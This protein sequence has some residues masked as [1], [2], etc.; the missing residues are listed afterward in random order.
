MKK[1]F[2]GLFTALIS[3][4]C[5][6]QASD[7]APLT[8]EEAMRLTL[9]QNET[10]RA[11][12]HEQKAAQHERKAAFGL[13]LPQ[14]SVQGAYSYMGDDIGVD[15]NELKPAVRKGLEYL[16][17][18]GA[19]PPEFQSV[20]GMVMKMN[21]GLT[22]QEREF[23]FAGASVTF[24]LF[25]GGKIN[26][27]N[28]AA[29]IEERSSAVQGEV[30][31]NQLLLEL[32]ERYYGLGVA[33]QA[34]EVRKQVVEVMAVHLDDAIKL[35]QNGIIARGERLLVDVTMSAAQRDFKG[36][37]LQVKTINA[38]L[39]NTLNEESREFLPLSRLF[40]MDEIEPVQYYKDM[41]AVNN[42]LLRQVGLKRELAKQGVCLEQSA[43]M[44]QIALIGN[45][46]FADYQ[47][48]KA[49][50]K[51]MI[52]AG[53]TINLFDGLNKEHKLSASKQVVKQVELLQSK[54][55]KDIGVLV[56][57]L[58]NEMTDMH[59][60]IA[61][62]ETSLEFAKEYLRIRNAGFREG[63]SSATELMD[64]E[65]NL[66]AIRIERLQ[67]AYLYDLTLARLLEA[68]GMS[69]RFAEYAVSSRAQP[70]LFDE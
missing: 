60:R 26:V 17:G 27:A 25:M 37:Q 55:A 63:V 38:A 52:G 22:I 32:V 21:W 30:V 54:A 5:F 20:A 35:E 47:V 24:P 42:P 66:A 19:L 68:C 16:E 8:F 39:G 69:E 7:R 43:F 4:S 48:S 58:Y 1:V 3:F 62:I 50:P 49:L 13:R 18:S 34:L 40:I 12:E 10:I 14:I 2:S 31:R 65:L 44:P 41:A 56:E 64:A 46:R 59:D 15:I 70:I 9:T 28:E 33:H 11:Q 36:A 61:S 6:G 53:V 67:A 29:R 23:A 45:Y 51:W 57:Q